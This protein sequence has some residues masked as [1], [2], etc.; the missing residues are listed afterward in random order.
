MAAL[1]AGAATSIVTDVQSSRLRLARKLGATAAID[2]RTDEATTIAQDLTGGRGVDA[3]IDCT[4]S[5]SAIQTGL[6]S[7]RRGGTVVWVGTSDD[8]YTIPA[9]SAIRRGLTIRGIFRYRNTYPAAIDLI[10]GGRAPVA[11]LISHRFS[12]ERLPE[13]MEVARTGRDGA[14]KVIVDI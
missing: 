2:V 14:V 6:E 13:A 4:G 5:S 7:V 8:S 1:A 11:E 9:I 12:L 10:A 3:A